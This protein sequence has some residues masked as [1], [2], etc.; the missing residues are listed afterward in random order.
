MLTIIGIIAV[1]ILICVLEVPRLVKDKLIKELV[2]FTAL[3]LFG[4]II[5]IAQALQ[6]RIPNPMDLIITIYQPVYNVFQAWLS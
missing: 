5:S 4:T 1:V 2:V 3:L 6:I